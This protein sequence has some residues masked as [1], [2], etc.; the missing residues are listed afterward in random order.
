MLGGLIELNK[1]APNS[2]FLES[3]NRIAQAAIKELADS[4]MVIHDTCEPNGC[5]PDATQFKGVFSRNLQMLQGVSPN[6]IYKKV[7]INC[8]D[9]IWKNDRNSENQLGADWAGPIST[10]VDASTHSS[11]MDALVAAL[12]V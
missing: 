5:E 4:N 6:D 9:S 10:I 12:A 8:A 11:A 3:A 7:I 2:S 1:A